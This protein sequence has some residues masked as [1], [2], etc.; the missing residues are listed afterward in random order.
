MAPRSTDAGPLHVQL[1]ATLLVALTGLL[2]EI[3]P[4]APAFGSWGVAALVLALYAGAELW[5]VEIEFRNDTHTFT[6]T[7]V[8]LVIGL[9]L[10][11]VRLVVL[12]RVLSSLAVL[13]GVPNRRAG[14]IVAAVVIAYAVVTG[15][16]PSSTRAA[17]MVAA[18]SS[19]NE[20]TS[21]SFCGPLENEFAYRNE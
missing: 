10:L 13:A 11:P 6:F 8:P 12:V 18:P 4:T 16:R 21:C 9:M 20:Q 3:T 15:L 19:T 7:S 17:G 2:L 14:G 1:F 5:S